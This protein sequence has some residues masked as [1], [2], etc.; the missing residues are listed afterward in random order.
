MRTPGRIADPPYRVHEILLSLAIHFIRFNY[1]SSPDIFKFR[2]TCPASPVNFADS[3]LTQK[4]DI[5]AGHPT[6]TQHFGLIC[7]ALN[8]MSSV[9][10]AQT[11]RAKT[12]LV[13]HQKS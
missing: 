7:P 8:S 12:V 10:A 3:A 6:L 1:G 13:I 2:W 5:Q 11:T 9:A 4:T